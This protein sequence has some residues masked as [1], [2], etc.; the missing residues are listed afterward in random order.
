ME[1]R[2]ELKAV[3]RSY[4]I[5]ATPSLHSSSTQ[6]RGSFIKWSSMSPVHIM[7]DCSNRDPAAPLQVLLQG[8]AWTAFPFRFSQCCP[9]DSFTTAC[10]DV[11]CAVPAGY[12][13]EFLLHR[14][15]LGCR[16]LCFR[17]TAP[18]SAVTLKAGGL[19]SH[20]CILTFPFS[21]CITEASP[22][23]P[24]GS[25]L[26]SRRTACCLGLAL[27]HSGAPGPFSESPCCQNP[28]NPI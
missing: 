16:K 22:V 7:M 12:R 15:L 5:S 20:I 14:P 13:G 28:I 1:G 27:P 3:V 6:A 8:S 2:W 4:V 9:A 11:L 23:L 19:P 26:A 18:S 21:K 24:M 25:T 17:P 10:G